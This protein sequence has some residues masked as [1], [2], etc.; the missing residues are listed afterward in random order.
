M[1]S[2]GDIQITTESVMPSNI[3]I[4]IQDKGIG[5]NQG[6]LDRLGEPYFSTKEN[7]TG[8]GMMVS[9]SVIKGMG[10]DIKV[11]SENGKGTFFSI[12]LPTYNQ[13]FNSEV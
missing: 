3:R 7:G 11:K 1:T 12:Q 13:K 8:L 5:M 10:G 2:G 4:N 6:Q 9:F